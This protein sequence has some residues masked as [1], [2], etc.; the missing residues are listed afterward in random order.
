MAEMGTG[1]GA[2][3]DSSQLDLYLPSFWGLT[4]MLL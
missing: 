2:D 1:D 4:T 3:N